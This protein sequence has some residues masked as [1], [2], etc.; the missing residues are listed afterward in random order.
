MLLRLVQ[1]GIF[2]N[3]PSS[4]K[5]MLTLQNWTGAGRSNTFVHYRVCGG[6][7]RIGLL[8]HITHHRFWFNLWPSISL[9]SLLLHC[10]CRI[11]AQRAP[12]R[13]TDKRQEEGRVHTRDRAGRACNS[14][15]LLSTCVNEA[16]SS[17]NM[18][19]QKKLKTWLHDWLSNHTKQK[20]C[21]PKIILL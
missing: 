10:L 15:V 4:T 9:K 20:W 2:S 13:Q 21:N 19:T 14:H 18:G 7:E 8:A 16:L 11:A 1:A 17:S 3:R 6:S 5:L 12:S